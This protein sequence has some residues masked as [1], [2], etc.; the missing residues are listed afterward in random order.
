MEIYRWFQKISQT[1]KVIVKLLFNESYKRISA[2]F[3]K[4]QILSLVKPKTFST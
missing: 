1:F 2:T 3:P 4:E